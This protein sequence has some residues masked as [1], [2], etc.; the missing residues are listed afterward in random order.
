MFKKG[1]TLIELMLVVSVVSLL[2]SV[3]FVVSTEAKQKGEDSRKLSQVKEVEKAINLHKQDNGLVPPNYT[4]NG[5][6]IAREGT[7]QYTQSMQQLV[8]KGY[9]SAIPKS[10]SGTD[11]TYW[12]APDAT[13]AFFGAKLSTK[14]I[15]TKSSCSF[16]SPTLPYEDCGTYIAGDAPPGYTVNFS[17]ANETGA[18]GYAICNAYGPNN[19]CLSGNGAFPNAT[20]GIFPIRQMCGSLAGY[21]Y[22]YCKPLADSACAGG[23]NDYC[24]CVN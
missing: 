12:A 8:N 10:S 5:K 2:S 20:C 7:A 22:L 19:A 9:I 4:S 3:F 14:T 18:A 16:K 24:A 11:Y 21:W 1:F 17:N 15:S 13:E 6:D 23:T